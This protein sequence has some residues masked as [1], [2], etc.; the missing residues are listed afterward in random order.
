MTQPG[1]DPK[2][3]AFSLHLAGAS[4]EQIGVALGMSPDDVNQAVSAELELRQPG[5]VEDLATELERVN[6]LWRT[7]Y[8]KAV[9]GDMEAGALALRL[10]DY[11]SDLQAR[12][13]TVRPPS[14]PLEQPHQAVRTAW[15]VLAGNAP[16]VAQTLVDIALHGKNEG[17]RVTA[18][19]AVMDRV[20]LGRVERSEIAVH[21]LDSSVPQGDAPIQAGQLVRSRLAAIAARKTITVDAD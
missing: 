17:V 19:I 12:A 5:A 10:A 7:I 16:H 1:T 2:A 4:A 18:S 15:Q 21:L 8:T 20:G 6:A 13:G 3:Q 14:P 9:Q 11:R